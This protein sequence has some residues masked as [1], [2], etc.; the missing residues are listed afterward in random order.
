[1]LY[2]TTYT[3]SRVETNKLT[4]KQSTEK[5]IESI[6]ELELLLLLFARA[7]DWLH[8]RSFLHWIVLCR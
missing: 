5:H 1:M 6:T 4:I 7:M 8:I 2:K 3:H